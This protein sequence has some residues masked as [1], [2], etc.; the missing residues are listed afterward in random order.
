MWFVINRIVRNLEC[1]NNND[2]D[3]NNN[4]NNNNVLK[5]VT[6]TLQKLETII[7]DAI[8]E[9]GLTI[10]TN[11]Y[12]IMRDSISFWTDLSWGAIRKFLFTLLYMIWIIKKE[13]WNAFGA[14][15][16]SSIA[17]RRVNFH[18]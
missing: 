10:Q 16:I 8:R 14:A 9:K 18:F 1:N 3:N 13:S 6:I 15:L 4:N 12:R 11:D 2:N 7:C 17:H 5:M